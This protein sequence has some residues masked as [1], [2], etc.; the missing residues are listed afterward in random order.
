MS[1]LGS[2]KISFEN[3]ESDEPYRQRSEAN[4]KQARQEIKKLQHQIGSLY[5]VVAAAKP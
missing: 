5:A 3:L 1:K 2:T 4:R